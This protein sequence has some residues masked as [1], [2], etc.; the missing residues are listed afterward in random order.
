MNIDFPKVLAVLA[1]KASPLCRACFT[2]ADAVF[3]RHSIV[4]PL[5]LPHAMAQFLNETG[6]L[7]D[8][9]LVENL[10]YSAE[11]LVEYWPRHFTP[12]LAQTYGRS[13]NDTPEIRLRKQ[14]AIANR[15]YGGRNGNV[16]PNDGFNFRGRGIIQITGRS[17]YAAVDSYLHIGLVDH[18]ELACDPRYALPVACVVWTYIKKCNPLADADD[19]ESITK[20]VNGGDIGLESRKAWLVKCKAVFGAAA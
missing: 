9:D 16:K 2:D 15:A 4:M 13:P 3:H 8:V 1:P 18:P 11:K 6:G 20:L 10:N 19:I 7:T 5:R 17:M 12:I 14:M